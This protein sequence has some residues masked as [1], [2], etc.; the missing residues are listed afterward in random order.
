MGKREREEE[1]NEDHQLDVINQTYTASEFT[2][3]FKSS[4]ISKRDFSHESGTM[5]KSSPFP[6][7]MLKNVLDVEFASELKRELLSLNYT[8]KSND[9]YDFFQSDNLHT[10]ELPE[11]K[12]FR[13]CLSSS[14][15][16]R[17]MN[18]LTGIELDESHKIDLAGQRYLRKGNLLCHDDELEGR[19]IA[20]ILYLV[21]PTW[22]ESDGGTLNLYGCDENRLPQNVETQVVPAFNSFAFFEVTP[23]SYHSI[24][25]I[26]S[27]D[28]ERVT[29][30]GWFYGPMPDFDVPSFTPVFDSLFDLKYWINPDYLKPE[31]MDRIKTAF[32]DDSSIQLQHFLLKDRYEMLVQELTALKKVS[33][34]S[35]LGQVETYCPK[36]VGKYTSWLQTNSNLSNNLYNFLS[37]FKSIEFL[38]YLKTITN[39]ALRK[40]PVSELRKFERG[41]YT[42][43]HDKFLPPVGLDMLFTMP[44]GEWKEEYGGMTHYLIEKEPVL[45]LEPQMN[46]LNLV[47]RDEGVYKFVKFVNGDASEQSYDL[48]YIFQE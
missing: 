13:D 48:H 6:V 43:I 14:S 9:L 42:L 34:T 20:F 25:E 35:L 41:D 44:T 10:I 46:T 12:K 27:R 18:Q 22:N 2:R 36:T 7:C 30:T 29:I 28:K 38:E 23:T 24:A 47:Y 45:S 19:R 3:E 21:D 37:F 26:L 15:F 32:V 16:M 40:C 33:V 39:L 11:L 31:A 8:E 17:L 4:F 5:I 1:S